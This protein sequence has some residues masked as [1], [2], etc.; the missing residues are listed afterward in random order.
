MF[1]HTKNIELLRL[2]DI[3]V[4]L[5]VYDSDYFPPNALHFASCNI[6][7]LNTHVSRSDIVF[8]TTGV[9]QFRF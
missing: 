7:N 8:V 3:S 2:L 6:L 4:V 1:V 9:L 5:P